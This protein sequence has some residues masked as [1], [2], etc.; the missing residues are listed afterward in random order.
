MN[1]VWLG[2]NTVKHESVQIDYSKEI[3]QL[4]GN[5][6]QIPISPSRRPNA[7]IEK[8]LDE[9]IRKKFV[10]HILTLTLLETN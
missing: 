3:R 9:N 1:N 4:Q 6:I 10:C 8:T 2:S 5:T 7:N